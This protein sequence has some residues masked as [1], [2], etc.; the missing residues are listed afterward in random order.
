MRERQI[1]KKTISFHKKGKKLQFL[2]SE[3]DR[4]LLFDEVL[5]EEQPEDTTGY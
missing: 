5:P 2:K 1:C 4:W 3:I